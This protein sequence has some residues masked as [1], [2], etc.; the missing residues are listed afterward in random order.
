MR[1]NTRPDLRRDEPLVAGVLVAL[2]LADQPA[3]GLAVEQPADGHRGR[4]LLEPAERRPRGTPGAI[5]ESA[6]ITIMTSRGSACR[7]A[8]GQLLV[9]RTGLLLGVADRLD[10]LDPVLAG[11]LDGGVGAVVGDDQD[12]VRWAGL[13]LPGTRSVIAEDGS[14]L[15]AGIST[16]HRT[17]CTAPVAGDSA[18][19]GHS[20]VDIT[21]SAARAPA[22]A[23]PT[24]RTWGCCFGSGRSGDSTLIAAAVSSAATPT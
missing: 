19:A 24:R 4:V 21:G 2:E 7:A 23:R 8:A 11:D 20:G 10:D 3:A 15:C 17:V 9:E 13:L 18:D 6:S 1:T 22:P 12:P 16:V 14:S 5:V